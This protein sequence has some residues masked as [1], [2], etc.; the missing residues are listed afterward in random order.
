MDAWRVGFLSLDEAQR[1]V[2]HMLDCWPPGRR[3]ARWLAAYDYASRVFE[4]W[5]N[6]VESEMARAEARDADA[7]ERAELAHGRAARPSE[8][9]AARVGGGRHGLAGDSLVDDICAVRIAAVDGLLQDVHAKGRRK[10]G[11]LP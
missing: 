8:E 9:G 4:V 1:L 3:D 10:E 11:D 5:Q 6:Q 7:Y 2:R